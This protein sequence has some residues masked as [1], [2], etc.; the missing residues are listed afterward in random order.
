MGNRIK[1]TSL[2]NEPRGEGG[3]EG[4]QMLSILACMSFTVYCLIVLLQ[5]KAG[6]QYNRFKSD[7]LK[8][9]VNQRLVTEKYILYITASFNATLQCFFEIFRRLRSSVLWI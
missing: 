9:A 1:F 6:L 8:R 7:I 3:R 5:V 4:G 2:K